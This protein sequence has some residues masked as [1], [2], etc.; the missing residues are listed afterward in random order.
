M[1]SRARE[2]NKILAFLCELRLDL[3]EYDLVS[4]KLDTRPNFSL[5]LCIEPD[6][7]SSFVS[8]DDLDRWVL[9]SRS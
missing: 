1:R 2:A 7:E 5:E 9:H 3:D 8:A 6:A 4:A